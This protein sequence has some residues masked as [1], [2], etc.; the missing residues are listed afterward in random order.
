MSSGA[1]KL[2][3]LAD[4]DAARLAAAVVLAAAL[5]LALLA[6]VAG[7]L[8]VRERVAPSPAIEMRL[9]EIAPPAP[10]PAPV[11]RP[12]AEPPAAVVAKHI[13][14]P[15]PTPPTH[16]AAPHG[17][18]PPVMT[19]REATRAANAP[20]AQE[21]PATP[22]TTPTTPAAQT[23]P[24][25]AATAASSNATVSGNASPGPAGSAR[26]R[27]LAQPMPVLPDDLREQGY[28]LT[29]VAHFRIHPDGSFDVELAKPTQ[30]PRLNQ[31]L[32]ETLHR[33]RFFP[34]MENG[35][36]VESEQD[37]RVHFVVS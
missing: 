7:W 9:V 20:A 15:T 1:R 13:P 4:R 25:I 33:W 17:N 34:A 29:A 32:L 14:V 28:A 10:A 26:A 18:P 31:I 23:A 21:T 19:A 35:H 27:V 22:S 5:C 2:F 16:A 37:V 12:A 8:S 6:H 24:A 30:N 11:A 3:A 36:P